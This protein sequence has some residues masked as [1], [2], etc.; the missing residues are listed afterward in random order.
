MGTNFGVV[1]PGSLYR[2]GRL[3]T[4]RL[5]RLVHEHAIRTSVGLGA[6]A[7]D[8][9]REHR[10]REASRRLGVTRYRFNLLGRGTGNP[11]CY[12]AALKV[13]TDPAHQPALVHC[14]AGAQRTGACVIL[15]RRLT[16]G[17]TVRQG[18]EEAMRFKHRPGGHGWRMLAYLAD[19]ADEILHAVRNDTWVEGHPVPDL[20][21]VVAPSGAGPA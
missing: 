16:Q 17:W 7:E 21:P 18:Y 4:R 10:I 6:L 19:H 5:E 20:Q 15:Y 13:L 12:A 2:S 3:S 1:Q 11:N 8:D 9:A 14:A